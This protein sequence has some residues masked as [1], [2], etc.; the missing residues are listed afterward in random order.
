MLSRFTSSLRQYIQL[1]LVHCCVALTAQR[2]HTTGWVSED[3][4]QKT[5]NSY[6]FKV[7]GMTINDGLRCENSDKRS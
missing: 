6:A 3:Y 4:T 5:N 1:N 2:P 7:S